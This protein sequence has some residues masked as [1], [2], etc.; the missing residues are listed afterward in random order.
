MDNIVMK[1]FKIDGMTCLMCEKTIENTLKKLDGVKKVKAS[2][3]NKTVMI[4]YDKN[5]LDQKKIASSLEKE[6]YIIQTNDNNKLVITSFIIILGLYLVFKNTNLFNF[7]PE[8]KDNIGYGLL[9]VVG[10][11]TSVHCI[12]MCGGINIS[13]SMDNKFKS[14]FLYNL[15]RITSYT[16]IGGIA[17]GIGSTI[18]FNDTFKDMVSIIAGLFMIIMGLN[19]TNL[20]KNSFMNIHMPKFIGKIVNRNKKNIRSPFIIGM[21]NGLMPCGPLQTMQL[22]ALGT[23]SIFKGS[24]SMFFFSLGTTP[25]ML[26][27]STLSSFI[28][29][30]MGVQ[31]KKLSGVLVV[32][33]GVVMFNRGFDY[34]FITNL[35]KPSFNS[36]NVT[37]SV[38][39][40]GY[41]EV[42]TRFENGRYKPIVVQKG[43]PVKWTIVIEDGDLNGCNNSILIKEYDIKKDLE[44]GDN[45]VTFIPD[46]IGKFKYTCWMKMIAS[47]IYVVDDI[48][49]IN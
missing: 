31:L 15:G 39:K 45:L 11:L 24:L 8:I 7:V 6:G 34:S 33:L 23:G 22:Y 49:S 29:G 47:S 14:G 21:L 2:F 38:I 25:L 46:D 48:E 28:S 32:L 12:A 20:F 36:N 30:K 37:I 9:F 16:V 17:G 1:I 43:I 5:I 4:K 18:A 19:M 26:G 13:V 27:L 40:D 42:T 35:S 41:Q 3:K 44:Y 10:L